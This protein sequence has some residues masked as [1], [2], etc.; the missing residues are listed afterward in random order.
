MN[1]LCILSSLRKRNMVFTVDL[2]THLL[3]WFCGSL[4]RDEARTVPL[5]GTERRPRADWESWGISPRP[6]NHQNHQVR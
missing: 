4:V 3:V 5:P 2:S 6:W 1:Y